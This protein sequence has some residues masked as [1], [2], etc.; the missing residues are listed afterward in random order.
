MSSSSS[1]SASLLTRLPAELRSRDPEVRNRAAKELHGHVSS[2]LRAEA[3]EEELSAFLDALTKKVL[4]LVQSPD[5][6]AKM[7]GVMAVVAL[8][9]ADVCNTNDRV[10]RFGNYLRNNCLPP[11]ASDPAVVAMAAR[12]FA[13]LTQVSGTHTANV[14]FELI[15]HEVKR[16]FEVLSGGAGGGLG[17]LGDGPRGGGGLGG[18]G[19]RDGAGGEGRQYAA[20]LLLREIAF[21]MPTFFF[22]N[23][24]RFFEVSSHATP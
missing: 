18:G 9:N 12:A 8:V 6:S 11:A 1:S 15:D 22:Q 17:G 2:E 23:I 10:S 20:V 24:S 13:R 5:P 14:K 7:G 21:S 19:G 4:D 3:S 16:A